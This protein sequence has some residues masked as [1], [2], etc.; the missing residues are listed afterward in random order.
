[1]DEHTKRRGRPTGYPKSGGRKRGTPNRVTAALKD[2]ILAAAEAA[3]GDGGLVGYLTELAVNEPVAF[4]GLLGKV[5]PLTVTGEA[6]SP[7]QITRIE[8]VAPQFANTG[9]SA[10]KHSTNNIEY[11]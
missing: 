7:L 10:G 9:V 3:G 8:L 1:M 11:H 2:A 5:L 6:D 4:A